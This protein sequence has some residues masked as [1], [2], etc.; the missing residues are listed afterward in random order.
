[1]R[2]YQLGESTGSWDG[3][4]VHWRAHV[5]CW[6]AERAKSLEGDF[7]ECGVNKGGLALTVMHYVEFQKLPKKFYLLDTFSGLP[8]KYVLEEEKALGRSLGGYEEC[9]EQVKATFEPFDN[10]VI[11]KGAVPE[12]L[13]QV[14]SEAIAYLSIDM[15]CVEP[16]IATAEFF[17]EKLVSGGVMLLDDYGWAGHIL[18]KRAFDRFAAERTVPI[19]SLPT[20]QGV[21]IKP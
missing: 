14:K 10:V 13:P 21:I 7:V 3:G 6:A 19:L 20:G 1:M 11:V 8:D 9:Y 4:K 2:A 18:Q 15:N 12:T 17:W 5:A 16:E